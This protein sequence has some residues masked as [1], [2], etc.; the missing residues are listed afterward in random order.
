VDEDLKFHKRTANAATKASR[1]LGLIRKT[2]TLLGE[3]TL[4]TLFTAIIRPHLEY[5][6]VMRGI[7]ETN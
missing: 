5:G 7:E 2:F 3:T 4:P 6:N 1:M